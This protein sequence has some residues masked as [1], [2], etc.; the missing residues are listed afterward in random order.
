MR[1]GIVAPVLR[2]IPPIASG[3]IEAYI[4]ELARALA[5]S[6]HEVVLATTGDST[7][8]VNRIH[9][10]PNAEIRAQGN[11]PREFMHVRYAYQKFEGF[12]AIL[13]FTSVG[14][15]LSHADSP[16][17]YAYVS[18]GLS[19]TLEDQARRSIYG[20]CGPETKLF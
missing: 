3:L 14:P 9:L 16:N 12:D 2:T 8:P 18:G 13:D 1:L 17:V 19:D 7:C 5:T 10:L 15:L 20:Q 4:D 6:P 11:I